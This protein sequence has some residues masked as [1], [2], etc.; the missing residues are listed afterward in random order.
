MVLTEEHCVDRL[1]V[2]LNPMEFWGS[3]LP[4]SRACENVKLSEGKD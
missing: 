1:R 4:V 3:R 2:S